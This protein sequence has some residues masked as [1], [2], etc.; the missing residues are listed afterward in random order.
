M[1][2]TT[3]ERFWSKVD[4]SGGPDACWPWMGCTNADGYGRFMLAGRVEQS[5][6]VAY[7]IMREPIDPGLQ[8]D[9]L[10]RNRCCANPKHMEIVTA[11]ENTMRGISPPAVNSRKNHC[12]KG[13]ELPKQSKMVSGKPRRPCPQCNTAKTRRIEAARSVAGQ[14]PRCGSARGDRWLCARCLEKRNEC[15]RI[16]R[17]T[18]H[19]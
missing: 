10:C 11:A 1:P 15:A 17:A 5:H 9:H 7:V 8:V 12:P 4:T 13:H 18:R 16:R 3:E 19:V 2:R 6:R 14:C